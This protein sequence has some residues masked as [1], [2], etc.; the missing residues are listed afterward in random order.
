M[1]PQN[2][3]NVL[4]TIAKISMTVFL[5]A[6]P[7]LFYGFGRETVE[8][9]FSVSLKNPRW[10][11]FLIGCV[12]FIPCYFAAKRLFPSLWCYLETLE[13]ELTHL[14][15]GLLFLKIPVGIRVSAHAGGEVRHIGL[16]RTGETWITLAPYF[17]PT[18]SVFVLFLAYLF[19][20]G[21][22]LLL[23]V[24]GWSTV[25]HT[26][27]NWSETS[28]RQPDLRKA[29]FV[30][31]IVILPVMNLICYGSILAFVAGGRKGFGNFWSDAFALS[32]N[33]AKQMFF[34]K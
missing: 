22:P 15:A 21:T 11:W 23:G 20:T 32:F 17:F 3:I 9:I 33:F 4:K 14:I 34:G 26:V 10:W 25:F 28:F 1:F 29:G 13:H 5:L 6:T 18:V 7:F 12:A 24:L 31:S 8:I 27:T 19:E 30:K 2:R 16:G